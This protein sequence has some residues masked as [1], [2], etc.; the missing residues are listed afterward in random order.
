MFKSFKYIAII[1]LF[2]F[3]QQQLFGLEGRPKIRRACLN[4]NDSTITMLWYAPTDNCGSFTWFSLYGREDV[5]SIYK[6]MG[7]YTN[8]SLNAIQFK[9]PNLKDWEFYLIYSNTCNGTD[10]IYSDTIMIDNI[11]PD[12]SLIDSVS[13]DFSTQTTTI[14][15]KQNISKDVRGYLLYYVTSTNAVI[16]NTN[17]TS[18]NDNNPA[19]NPANASYKY[20]IAAYDSCL[21]TSLISPPHQTIHLK[22]SYDQCKKTIDLNWTGTGYLGWPVQTYDI[23]LSINSAPY[24]NIGTVVNNISQFTYNFST[25]GDQYCFYIR[26]KKQGE[27]VTS[28]SNITCI[29]SNSLIETDDSYIAKVS[30]QN[31]MV[32]L[33]L[34]TQVGTSLQKINIYKA[35]DNN[36][37]SLW[38]SVPYTGGVYEITDQNVKVH[39][40]NYRYYFVTEGPCNLLFDTSQICKTI[41]LNVQMNAPGDQSLNWNEYFE[42]IKKTD[43]QELLLSN[44]ANSNKS[45]PWNILSTFTP[46]VLSANDQTD[47]GDAQEQICYCIR[48]IENSPNQFYRRQDTSYSNVECVK[49][50]PIIYF[51]DAIQLNGFNNIFYPKGVFLDYSKCS[52]QIYNRWGQLIFETSDI[53]KGWDG[54][55]AS[56]EMV[57]QDVYA[58]KSFITGINGKELVFDG[59]VTVLK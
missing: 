25:F 1:G 56:G 28:S 41:L 17:N 2:F 15:W 12:N 50:D 24:Q 19:R 49:A 32:E 29:S 54:K 35:E 43:K 39:S 13:V 48:A 45:S 11:E 40:R 3:I 4:R 59:T 8:F 30:T 53:V 55:L 44:D 20:S 23:Y 9:I 10:S 46:D 27:N 36:G 33:T 14:G 51:P 18:A 42:F 34:I 52:F 5:F 57:E 37:F 22:S 26:A 6:H 38:A 16:G 31:E 21:N 58:Y 7:R 47:F